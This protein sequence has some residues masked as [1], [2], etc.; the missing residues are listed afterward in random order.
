[1]PARQHFVIV[2][3]DADTRA[4]LAS[5]LSRKYPGASVQHCSESTPACEAAK[6]SPLTAF[7]VWRASDAEGLPL[8]E[9]LRATNPALP[10]LFLST[11]DFREKSFTAGA[12]AF[13][14]QHA[15]LRVGS[16]VEDMLRVPFRAP[17]FAG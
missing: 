5:T 2:A 12:S 3:D 1:M 14:H 15:W 13:L 7:I 10:I 17:V 11:S 16:A 8:L 9:M 6:Q 4:L